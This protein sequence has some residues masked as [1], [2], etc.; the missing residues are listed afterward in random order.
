MRWSSAGGFRSGPKNGRPAGAIACRPRRNGNTPAND[1]AGPE[2]GSSRVIRG[3]DW[4]GDA[5][6]CRS[7]FRNAEIP[8]GVFYVMGFRVAMVAATDAGKAADKPADD[9][10]SSPAAGEV[11]PA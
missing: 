10:A 1:P 8:K 11:S 3:G 7:A 5:R 9:A 2:S 6:D 4:Y